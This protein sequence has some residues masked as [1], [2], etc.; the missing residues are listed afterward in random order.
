MSDETSATH[1]SRFKILYFLKLIE[2]SAR[3]NFHKFKEVF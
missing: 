3:N 2:Y 1:T